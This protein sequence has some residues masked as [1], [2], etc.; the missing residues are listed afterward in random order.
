MIPEYYHFLPIFLLILAPS[1]RRNYSIEE[2]F[3]A[4]R[5]IEATVTA[6]QRKFRE[7][8]PHLQPK[9]E[10]SDFD[11]DDKTILFENDQYTEDDTEVDE[12]ESVDRSRLYTLIFLG[13]FSFVTIFQTLFC[14]C[15]D[16]IKRFFSNDSEPAEDVE[17]SAALYIDNT[18]KGAAW[19]GDPGAA[20]HGPMAPSA[21]PP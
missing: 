6:L 19:A 9:K 1:I 12:K 7:K 11:E 5:Q 2:R 18:R 15:Y 13:L 20:L 4:L 17:R 14:K 8:H 10:E 3:R 16:G 21:P